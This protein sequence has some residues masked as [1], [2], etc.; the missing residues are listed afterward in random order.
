MELRTEEVAEG[1]RSG[2][3]SGP[4]R[5]DLLVGVST[6]EIGYEVLIQAREEA[7]APLEF[8]AG[9]EVCLLSKAEFDSLRERYQIPDDVEIRMPTEGERAC[10]SRRSEL[11]VNIEMFK[12]GFR[13]PVPKLVAEILKYYQVA[14]IQLMPNS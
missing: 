11:C 6:Y 10:W 13:V 8:D 14:L 12:A 7:E 4:S 5:R 2:P 1:R 3:T 9:G